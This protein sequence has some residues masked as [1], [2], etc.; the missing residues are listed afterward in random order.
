MHTNTVSQNLCDSF[1]NFRKNAQYNTRNEEK[2]L[3]PTCKLDIFR[4][5]FI[6]DAICKWNDLPNDVI[7]SSTL[8]Q[9]RRSISNFTKIDLLLCIFI[10]EHTF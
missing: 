8:G 3:V 7:K 1:V 2:Y 4:K 10:L 9:F 5:S 6:P